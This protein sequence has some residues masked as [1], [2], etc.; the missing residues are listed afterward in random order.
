VLLDDRVAIVSGI[1][2]GMGRD[3]SLAL[4]R[5]GADV[6]LAA[7]SQDRLEEVAGE[8]AR[9]GRRA[10]TVPTDITDDAQC[11]N[12]AETAVVELGGVD[13]L[14]NNAFRQP[15]FERLEDADAESWR[16]GLKVNLMGTM[17]L[18]HAVIPALKA[19]GSGSIV[20]INSMS[21]RRIEPEYGV[22]AA[23]KAA[24]LSAAK[25]LALELGEHGIRVNSVVP[26]YIYGDSVRMLFEMRA[27]E[28]GTTA[29]HEEELVRAETALRHIPTSAEIAETVVFYASDLS[30]VVTG[31]ALDVNGGHWFG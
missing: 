18:T 22:Y 19:R 31:T 20:F 8:V 15:P 13:V 28:N 29:E 2:P 16:K 6:V 12:L 11:R 5:E 26:G 4:A 7:R 25:T 30:R 21:A 24:L 14:V 3:I 23:G 17:Q 1:G 27:A 9:L 10:V